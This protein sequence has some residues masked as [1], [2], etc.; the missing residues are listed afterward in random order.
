MPTGSMS[1]VAAAIAADPSF[2]EA[3]D[4]IVMMGGVIERGGPLPEV[5]TNVGHDPE[6][7]QQV[8]DA[9]FERARP[10]AARRDLSGDRH[11]RAVRHAAGGRCAAAG[12]AADFIEQRIERYRKLPAMG[13]RAAAPVHDALTIAY[14]VDP[15]LVTLRPATVRVHTGDSP[16]RGRTDITFG[17]RRRARRDRPGRVAILRAAA[18][19]A[20][21]PLSSSQQ[22]SAPAIPLFP[23]R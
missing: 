4:E 13:G 8:L 19:V 16:T 3:V 11:R 1:N 18:R 22:L 6:A 10:R 15:T 14:L 17:N 7:A 23:T 9:G 12:V 2:V 20:D 5:E 21:Q